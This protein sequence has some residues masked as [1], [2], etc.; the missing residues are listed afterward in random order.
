MEI[1]A[2]ALKILAAD[3]LL[4]GVI[5]VIGLLVALWLVFGNKSLQISTV[6]FVRVYWDKLSPSWRMLP[7]AFIVILMYLI[8]ASFRAA[9]DEWISAKPHWHLGLKDL[10]L[11]KDYA[12]GKKDKDHD[13]ADTNPTE[14]QIIP[15][16][17]EE[18]ET[19][20][21]RLK[22]VYLADARKHTDKA[23]KIYA[24]ADLID[25]A[26]HASPRKGSTTAF[27]CRL[28]IYR[29]SDKVSAIKLSP[30]IPTCRLASDDWNP[31]YEAIEEV[32]RFYHK[33]R[34]MQI[35][36]EHSGSYKYDSVA[37][38]LNLVIDFARLVAFLFL[39]LALAAF[40]NLILKGIIALFRINKKTWMPTTKTIWVSLV[41]CI[42]IGGYIVSAMAW[43]TLEI[44]NNKNIFRKYFVS[45]YEEKKEAA[46]NT[47]GDSLEEDLH[48]L[49]LLIKSAKSSTER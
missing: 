6:N 4:F 33:I 46:Q 11:L 15:R 40:L 19:A 7:I 20:K 38:R 44:N 43:Q 45:G 29:L 18:N 35:A 39:L 10:W 21:D 1:L 30:L 48:D 47:A 41:F 2:E 37:G 27:A 49:G 17:N 28:R 12:Y 8:G 14:Y 16:E 25:H 22:R 42:S 32:S 36:R 9:A 31:T 34:Q 26:E 23:L 5:S 24:L 13:K 3:V